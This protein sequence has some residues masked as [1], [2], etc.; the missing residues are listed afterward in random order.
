MYAAPWVEQRTHCRLVLSG[1][2]KAQK[3]NKKPVTDRP[4]VNMPQLGADRKDYDD[5][6]QAALKAWG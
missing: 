3:N 6:N 1:T 4:T 2:R 5:Y